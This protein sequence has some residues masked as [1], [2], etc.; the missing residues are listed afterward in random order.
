MGGDLLHAAELALSEVVTKAVLHAHTPFEV[1]LALQDDGA[2]HVE[3]VD[4]NPQLPAR[5]DYA[6]PATTG[7]GMGVVAACTC[8]RDVQSQGADGK[9]VW[10][11]VAPDGAVAGPDA[12][13]KF[14]AWDIKLTEPVA[15]S[16]STDGQVVT[17]LGLPPAPWLAA[18]EHHD[19]VLRK[20]ALYRA[21]HP[22]L[23]LSP[24][25][26]ALANQAR[27]WMSTALLAALARSA[28]SACDLE[29]SVPADAPAAFAALREVLDTAEQLAA[30]GRLL[31]R[32]ALP[33][34]VAVRDWVCEQ[35]IA[36]HRGLR[37]APW[38]G[39]GQDRFTGQADDGTEP[40]PPY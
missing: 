2:L 24:E 14:A 33:R 9:V 35:V 11:F 21:E 25:R 10:F 20:L 1:Y 23:V 15:S 16:D 22:E 26:V 38:P 27:T 30:D 17:L 40:A 13:N 4:L 7:R 3:L 28:S 37:P 39:T 36:Q 31:A 34:I 18:R 5:R 29:P 8:K 32:P 6:E 12:S 19:A